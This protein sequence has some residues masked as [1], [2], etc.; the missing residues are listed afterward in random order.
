METNLFLYILQK[1]WWV[2]SWENS[3]QP[4]SSDNIQEIEK[5]KGME[6][7]AKTT[8]RQS[9]KK[10]RFVLDEVRNN[11]V[12]AALAKLRF[13]NKKAAN[14]IHQTISSAI[15]NMQQAE[16]DFDA[17]NL[18]IKEA[19]VGKSLSMKRFRPRAKGRASKIIKPFSKLTIVLE[20][21][22]KIS[23]ENKDKK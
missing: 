4:A 8:I 15:S 23:K 16:S 6:S 17:D 21:R 5:L 18:F 14:R 7:I 3:H 22:N 2:I 12:N 9:A 19:Y 13:M 10:V 1:I 11:N 20:E